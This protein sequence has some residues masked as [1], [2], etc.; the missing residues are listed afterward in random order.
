MPDNI[1]VP[2]IPGAIVGLSMTL[3]ARS[4]AIGGAMPAMPSLRR[5][6]APIPA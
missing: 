3:R 1:G 4:R 5:N 2:T 6:P